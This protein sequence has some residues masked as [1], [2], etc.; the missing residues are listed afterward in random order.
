MNLS[1][2]NGFNCVCPS[3]FTGEYCQL[4]IDEC[5]SYPCANSAYCLDKLGNFE[6][7]CNPG[8]TGVLCDQ[9]IDFCDPYPCKNGAQCIN[10]AE[11]TTYKCLCKDGWEGKRCNQF[12][13]PCLSTPCQNSGE[14]F[15]VIT[16]NLAKATFECISEVYKLPNRKKCYK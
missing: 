3:G 10:M 13:D 8:F 11:D 2:S 4:E 14:C 5:L 6:C 1:L 16:P 15:S 7:I 12:H 9:E